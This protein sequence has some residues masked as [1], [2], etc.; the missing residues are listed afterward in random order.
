MMTMVDKYLTTEMLEFNIHFHN[1][2]LYYF[3]TMA[4]DIVI[5]AKATAFTT[6]A[7]KLRPNVCPTI[8]IMYEW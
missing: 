8:Q 2:V 1:S 4:E 7:T 6:K 3:Y 5:Y